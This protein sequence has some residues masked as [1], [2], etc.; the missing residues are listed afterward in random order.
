MF[1][2]YLAK[3]DNDLSAYSTA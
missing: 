1:V 3:T 2:Q